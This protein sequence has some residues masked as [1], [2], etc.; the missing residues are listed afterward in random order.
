MVAKLEEIVWAMNPQHDSLGALV[1]YFTFLADRLLGLAN[2]KLTIE[3]SEDTKSLAV[4][5]RL[6]HQLFLVFKEAL[7]NVIR[8]SGA[9]E[10]RLAIASENRVL[11]VTV[12]DNGCGL[13]E[14]APTSG[15]HDGIANMRR[16]MEKLGGQFEITGRAGQGTTVRFSVSL[17][18]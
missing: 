4:D 13:R 8:H 16:R 2:I 11:N 14:T 1:S 18:S 17:D 9:S 5:A 6:R 10:V 3:T 12:S 15:G 7:A